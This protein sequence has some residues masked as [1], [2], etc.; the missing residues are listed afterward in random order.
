M[1]ARELARFG[2]LFLDEGRWQ[3]EQLVP[4]WWVV[5]STS[6]Q[7]DIGNNYAG[8]GYYWWL[9][10]IATYDMFSALGAGGQILHVIP[11]A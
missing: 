11:S 4:G 9:N 1:T 8:Y 5:A 3:D 10:R 7:V 2:Q 6:P